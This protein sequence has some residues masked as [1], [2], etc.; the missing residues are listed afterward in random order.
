MGTHGGRGLPSLVRRPEAGSFPGP[1]KAEAV[2]FAPPPR[3]DT[4]G[5]VNGLLSA[6]FNW[7]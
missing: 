6:L 1:L 3:L 7:K 4:T 2:P 5:D